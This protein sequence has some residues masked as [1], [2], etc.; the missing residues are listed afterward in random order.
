MSPPLR[1]LFDGWALI[2]NPGSPAALHLLAILE[3]YPTEVQPVVAVPEAPP[4]WF[5]QVPIQIQETSNLFTWEQSSLP[6][7]ARR[8]DADL[9]H[10]FSASAPLFGGSPAVVSPCSFDPI[11]LHSSL[12]TDKGKESLL[13]RARQSIQLGGLARAHALFLPNDLAT[14]ELPTSFQYLPPLV[15][16]SFTP[17]AQPED[18]KRHNGSGGAWNELRQLD[19]PD[20]YLLYHGPASTPAVISLLNAW[21]WASNAIGDYHPLLL[22]GFNAAEQALFNELAKPY[23]FGE[24]VRVLPELSFPVIA[25]LYQSCSAL[26]HPGT[27]PLWGGPIRHALAC[28]KPVVASHYLQTNRLV[29]PAAYLAPENDHRAQGA[30][31][32]TVIVEEEVSEKLAQA[33][34]QR[35]ST[36]N[37]MAYSQ[38][39]WAAYQKIT[40]SR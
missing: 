35:A 15:H 14:E 20:T 40:T 16:S 33:A 8:L 27:E 18:Y 22:L 37:G 23:D 11:G 13:S 31:L 4:E 38:A 26:F 17:T 28:G 7:L 36:W 12:T 3:N 32:I 29:G 25:M 19:L 2:R 6:R 21:R 30:A 39:L 10:L 24:T 1:V 5:P 34:R 9:L